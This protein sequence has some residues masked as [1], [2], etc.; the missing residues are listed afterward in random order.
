MKY[1]VTIGIPVYHVEKYIRQTMDSALAQSF[2]SIEF[3]ICDDCGTDSSIEIVHE[4]QEKHPRGKDIHIV[5]QPHNMGIGE[6]RNR[7]MAEAQGRYFY[8]LDADDMIS[9]NA[10]ELLYNAA[11]K[12]DAEIVYGSYERLFDNGSQRRT[13]TYQYPM[14]VF[15]KPDEYA[16]YVYNVGIQGM[17]WNY[18][19]DLDVVRRNHLKVTPVGHGYGEDFTYT[20]DLPTYITR[21]VLLPDITYQYYIE[22]NVFTKKRK[23]VISREQMDVAIEALETKKWRNELKGKPYYAQRCIKI[24]MYESSF[25]CQMVL[26]KRQTSP[27]YTNREICSILKSPMTFG[28]IM[29]L[30]RGRIK[31]LYY[32]VIGIMP[33]IFSILWLRLIARK[34]N[35][36]GE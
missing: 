26:R 22:E 28:E 31:N 20:V 18:L 17:N 5:R 35:M 15:L 11:K 14:K 7:M 1:E 8:S 10:I 12:Y 6:A 23:K 9:P 29:R 32:Y 2:D 34:F 30:K 24:L 16:E 4:Y 25:A 21:A 33:P 19:I 3:L 13:V 27:P 36:K